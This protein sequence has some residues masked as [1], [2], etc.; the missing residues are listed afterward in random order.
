MTTVVPPL[1]QDDTERRVLARQLALLSEPA[2][3]IALGSPVWAAAVCWIASGPFPSLG[4]APLYVS[5]PWLCAVISGCVASLAVDRAYRRAREL[6]DFDPRIWLQRHTIV[7]SILSA[8]WASLIWVFWIDGNPTN[9]LSLVILVLCGITNGV[10]SRMHRFETYLI[11]SGLAA[12]ILWAKIATETSDV[13]QIYTVLVPIWF[14]A[15]SMNVRSASELTRRDI[16]TQIENE[17][18][19]AA[20][21]KARD[22]AEAAR[23]AAERA[24]HMKSSFLANMSHELRTPLNAIL[25]FSEVIAAHG[26]GDAPERYRNYAQDIH[27]SGQHLLSLIN[28]ILDVAKIEAGKMKLDGSWLDASAALSEAV[29]LVRDKATEKNI[30]LREHCD[31]GLRLFGDERAFKQIALN[32][33]SNA[34][35]FTT[36]GHVTVSLTAGQGCA[37]LTVE[38]TGR[39]IPK[40]E[41]DRIFTAF[42]QVDNR[43]TH[44]RGGTGLGLTLVRALCELHGGSCIIE[45]EEGK[46]TRVEVRLPYPKESANQGGSNARQ[47]AA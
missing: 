12:A 27:G 20:I 6:P 46:G 47:R 44:A 7:A 32:L 4:V 9:Q 5:L 14:A 23:H 30:D 11:G 45:S 40:S 42:E 13:P 18:L 36:R 38:D 24:N 8:L 17:V 37:L 28:D 2:R 15:M 10:I 31:D 19:A 1:K 39:G 16:A 26:F 33:L 25:G 21:A 35:K 43:Y 34:I 41:L 3:G 29:K 22:D